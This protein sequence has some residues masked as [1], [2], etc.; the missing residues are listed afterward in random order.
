MVFG[1][2]EIWEHEALSNCWER[3]THLTEAYMSTFSRY[4]WKAIKLSQK[5]WLHAQISSVTNTRGVT[6]V[7]SVSSRSVYASLAHVNHSCVYCNTRIHQLCQ[8]LGLHRLR[9]YICWYSTWKWK[10]KEMR[11]TYENFSDCLLGF[12]PFI[13]NSYMIQRAGGTE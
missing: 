4:F 5:T 9:M 12:F 11:V 8:S 7:S 1:R 13:H 10:R 2:L 3:W 6:M